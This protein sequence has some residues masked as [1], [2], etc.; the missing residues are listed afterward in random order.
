MITQAISRFSLPWLLLSAV[1]TLPATYTEPWLWLVAGVFMVWQLAMF[2]ER[3]RYP[4][5]L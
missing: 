1:V 4:S 2:F 3:A 5:A